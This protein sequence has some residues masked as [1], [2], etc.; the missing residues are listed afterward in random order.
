MYVG[1]LESVGFLKFE[2]DW[3]SESSKKMVISSG[4]FDS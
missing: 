1:L 4:N 2:T 3:R